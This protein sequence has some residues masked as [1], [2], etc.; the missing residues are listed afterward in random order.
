MM[1]SFAAMT[2]L[3]RGQEIAMLR[4]ETMP[5]APAFQ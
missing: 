5:R 4:C 2:R 1:L 3:V